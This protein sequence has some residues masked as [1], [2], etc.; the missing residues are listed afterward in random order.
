M[1]SRGSYPAI[2]FKTLSHMGETMMKK[3]TSA[4]AAAALMTAGAASAATFQIDDNTSLTVGGDVQ[5]TYTDVTNA[6]GQGVSS[7][8]DNGSSLVFAGEQTYANGVTTSFYLDFDEFG[9]MGSAYNQ[10]GP[11]NKAIETDEYHVSFAGNFGEIK[12]GNEGDV[13]GPIFDVVDIAETTGLTLPAGGASTEVLQYYSNNL[14]GVSFAVQTQIHGDQEK[15]TASQNNPTS[16]SSTSL[17]GMIMADLGM[18]TAGAGYAERANT[19]DEPTYGVMVSS[20]IAGVDV[21]GNYVIQ[22]NANGFDANGFGLAADYGY[23]SGSIYGA[24]HAYG[25]DNVPAG[26]QD[27]FTQY[28]VGVNYDVTPSAYV[29]GE[30][31]SQDRASD[32]NDTMSVGLVYGF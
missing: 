19:Q 9:T 22:D 11:G 32:L 30:V 10:N 6:Q 29:Y 24:L 17:A 13:T 15:N 28:L 3:T 2:L 1:N 14:N 20:A 21:S 27:D 12:I 23:G 7:F 16:G 26:Q 31:S 18:F 8:T 25:I 4:L 5:F